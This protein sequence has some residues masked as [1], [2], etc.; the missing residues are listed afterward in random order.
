MNI[1]TAKKGKT[2]CNKLGFRSAIDKHP[3]DEELSD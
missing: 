1:S 2:H 3:N